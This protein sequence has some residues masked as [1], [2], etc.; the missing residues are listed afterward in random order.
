MIPTKALRRVLRILILFV[1]MVGTA[2][3]GIYWFTFRT[4]GT[5]WRLFA[6]GLLLSVVL[7]WWPWISTATGLVLALVEWIAGPDPALRQQVAGEILGFWILGLGWG[8]LARG[9]FHVPSVAENRP[10]SGHNQAHRTM[11]STSRSP[12]VTRSADPGAFRPRRLMEGAGGESKWTEPTDP[13]PVAPP[14]D[15]GWTP[16][17]ASDDSSIAIPLPSLEGPPA[18]ALPPIPLSP[19]PK[20]SPLPLPRPP[21]APMLGEYGGESVYLGSLPG[22]TGASVSPESTH[23]SL[24]TVGSGETSVPA[25]PSAP[26]IVSRFSIP[27]EPSV[28]PAVEFPTM[29]LPVNTLLRPQLP[30]SPET[31]PSTTGPASSAGPLSGSDSGSDSAGMRRSSIFQ[32]PETIPGASW[33][34]ILEWYN[35]FSWSP[36]TAPELERVYHRPGIQVGWETLALQDVVAVWKTWRQGCSPLPLGQDQISLKAFEGFLRCEMLGVLRQQGFPDLHVLSRADGADTWLAVYGEIRGRMRGGDAQI[37]RVDSGP[38]LTDP[39]SGLVGRPDRLAE[40]RGESDVIALVT[41]LSVSE[42]LSWTSVYALAQ[43][44]LAHAM[45]KVLSGTPVVVNLPLPIWDE[46]K[47]SRLV[48]VDD[49]VSEQRRLD[50]ALERFRRVLSGQTAPRAQTQPA[51]C[52]GCGWRHFCPSYQGTRPRLDLA[53][54]PA[55]V[56]AAMR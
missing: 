24:H 27:E 47:Q 2:G 38:A 55:Q 13:K 50:V 3:W 32:R 19:S 25:P 6:V 4:Q 48:T 11:E 12:A 54:P 5:D 49:L 36:W 33:E 23:P 28:V 41:P 56:S 31:Q 29:E 43:Y 45:G 14:L 9:Q 7:G 42:G 8:T 21:A 20:P 22:A 26:A 34:H 30:R 53:S 35:Q 37:H 15:L 51:T 40:I 10:S 16:K 17:P 18:S 52:S 44:R 1:S 46:R 39:E